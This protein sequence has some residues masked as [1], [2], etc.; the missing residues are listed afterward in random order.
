MNT[1]A[2]IQIPSFALQA[3]L[4]HE[5]ELREK[6][7]VLVEDTIQAASQPNIARNYDGEDAQRT[8]KAHIVQLTRAALNAGVQPG[9]SV[10]QARAR[11]RDLLVRGRSPSAETSAQAIL[12][13][14]AWSISSFVEN[15][16]PGLAT[17]Q[18]CENASGND[19][20]SD[21]GATMHEEAPTYHQ[22]MLAFAE[23]ATSTRARAPAF[24]LVNH[25]VLAH[26]ASLHFDARVGFGATPDLAW[27][28]AASHDHDNNAGS[29][30]VV[31]S[32]G[33]LDSISL[34]AFALPDAMLDILHRWGIR[35]IGGFLALG[36]DDLVRRLGAEAGEYFDRATGRIDRPLRCTQPAE[37]FEECTEFEH[38]LET[39]EPLLFLL[40]RMVDQLVLRLGVIY[41]VP[42]E[43]TLRLGLANDDE[44]VRVF[45]VP[46][47]TA[48]PDTLFRMLH[49]HL[50]GVVTEHPIVRVQ[51]S[52]EPTR[53]VRQQFGLFETALRD[54]NQFAETLA[55]L[56]A[57][58]GHDRVGTAML[59]PTHRPDAFR[60]QPADFTAEISR[61]EAAALPLGLSLRRFRPPQPALVQCDRGPTYLH[62][63]A[64]DG[65]IV[66]AYGPMLLSGDWWSQQPWSRAEW[67]VKLADGT[68]C[69]IYEQD[70]A[71]FLEG[72]YD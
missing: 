33:D 4:R 32:A 37:T 10:S 26:L 20:G 36:R 9:M 41:R 3:V 47:P 58:L 71:W 63:A 70:G 67:D 60:L 44:H 56:V 68:L 45:K 24:D 21:W 52:A 11:C 72:C 18:L 50:E 7:V 2:V 54:P 5:P 61:A 1:L 57:L 46:S 22:G 65:S 53:P 42:A 15:T 30:R 28:A 34:E 19:A 40:R 51:L 13:E 12:L 25:R 35:T 8:A 38:E 55:R 59:E 14:C 64:I 48:N 16:A 69:R 39:L 49:T 23:T 43:L 29:L 6:P 66:A 62:A 17:I 31:N 27:L